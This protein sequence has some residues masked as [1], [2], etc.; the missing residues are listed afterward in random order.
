MWLITKIF[1][2]ACFRPYLPLWPHLL[3]YSPDILVLRH[4]A[5]FPM[6]DGVCILVHLTYLF[7][8][9]TRPPIFTV[10][11]PVF[12][13]GLVC[14]SLLPSS[15]FSFPVTLHPS[16]E[17]FH[18]ILPTELWKDRCNLMRLTSFEGS[19]LGKGILNK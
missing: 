4:N 12:F 5:S 19:S 8:Y 17:W 7:S 10:E 2:S 9:S 11:N 15:Q 3:H 6:I 14:P 13:E 18:L 16:P 1:W